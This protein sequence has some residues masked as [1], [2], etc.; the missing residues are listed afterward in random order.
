M[1]TQQ[2]QVQVQQPQVQVPQQRQSQLNRS[3]T[4]G[5]GTAAAVSAAAAAAAATAAPTTAASNSSQQQQQPQQQ[6]QQAVLSYKQQP[7]PCEQLSRHSV[8]WATPW[9][10]GAPGSALIPS[11]IAP[12]DNA[13]LSSNLN[14]SNIVASIRQTQENI[15]SAPASGLPTA[16]PSSAASQPWH[17]FRHS[18][19]QSSPCPQIVKLVVRDSPS[20]QVQCDRLNLVFPFMPLTLKGAGGIMFLGCPSIRTSVRYHPW[21]DFDHTWS[22]CTPWSD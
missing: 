15:V 4:T 12:M 3:T 11:S 1:Q 18:G 2:Q 6:T 9:P 20:F 14:T 7:P 10:G 21:A 13:S 22:R 5:S 17:A 19:P 8:S 16:M